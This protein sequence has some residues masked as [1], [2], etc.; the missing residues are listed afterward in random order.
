[1]EQGKADSGDL[2]VQSRLRGSSKGRPGEILPGG[3]YVEAGAFDQAISEYE[4]ISPESDLF[5]DS[6]RKPRLMFD[7]T[8][9]NGKT[10]FGSGESLEVKPKDADPLPGPGGLFEKETAREGEIN[11]SK[12]PCSLTRTI[13][14]LFQLGRFAINW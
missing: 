8:E 14:N 13:R 1:L 9:E 4:K 6:R 2:G 12:R 7:E 3:G 11:T 10:P 5:S